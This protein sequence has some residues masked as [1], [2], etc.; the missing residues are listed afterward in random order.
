MEEI[1]QEIVNDG[2]PYYGDIPKDE[3]EKYAS[4]FGEGS[5]ELTNFLIYCFQNGIKTIGCCKGHEDDEDSVPYIALLPDEEL[6]AYLC[7]LI[8]NGYTKEIIV[9]KHRD[10]LRTI[11]FLGNEKEFTY[12][13]NDL[14]EYA[15]LK[16]QGGYYNPVYNHT[17]DAINTVSKGANDEYVITISDGRIL[18]QKRENYYAEPI[19]IMNDSYYQ[20]QEISNSHASKI[21]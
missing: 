3:I 14:Q 6:A 21:A 20:K 12:L 2:K 1:S 8:D 11:I 16:K 10:S 9:D 5:K 4:V 18:G 15:D 17:E 13:L 7:E 19:D